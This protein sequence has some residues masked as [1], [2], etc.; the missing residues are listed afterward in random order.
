MSH[1]DFNEFV[2]ATWVKCNLTD[3][4]KMASFQRKLKYLKGE[5]KKWNHSVF[6]NIFKAKEILNQEMKVVQQRM[7]TEGRSEELS[8][9]EQS[10][11]NL[12][13]ERES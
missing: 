3:G 8:K 10:L 1:P 12:L 2:K 9:K 4:T 13:L 5:I 11:E 7:I 6:G